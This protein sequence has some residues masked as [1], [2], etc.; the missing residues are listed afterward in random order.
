MRKR[1]ILVIVLAAVLVATGVTGYVFRA[2]IRATIDTISGVDY[3][4]N[5]SGSVKLEIAAGDSGEQVAQKLVDLGVTKDF[6]YTYKRIIAL[7]PKFIPGIF[8]LH[9]KMSANSALAMIADPSSR[10][11]NRVTVKEGLRISTVLKVLSE[12]SG[13]QRADF[14]S[15]VLDPSL[16]GLP[17]SLPNLDGYLF[18]ATYELE[19]GA[20]AES[21]IR[22]MVNRMND[23]LK[24]FGVADA[25]RHRVLTLASIVQKEAQIREDFYKVSRVFLNRIDQGMLL[26]SDATVSYGSG[27]HTVTTT[28]AERADP[29]G[30]NTYVHEGLPVGPIGAPGSL[31]IDA[32]LHPADGSWL[33]F[34]AVNLKTGETVFSNDYAGHAKAVKLW[35]KWMQENPGWNG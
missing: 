7:N 11:V 3:Q 27:G 21:I 20:S 12:A 5:G 18:P 23:E 15:A 28:D 30:Y 32:A 10:L 16:Y 8:T 33:Y 24:K 4:G 2:Q 14:D 19:P 22:M 13:I 29:N 9:L 26:Q 35:K 34:C 6:S 17:K 1:R 25:D 31:A